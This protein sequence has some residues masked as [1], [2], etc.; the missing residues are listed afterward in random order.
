MGAGAEG[1]GQAGKGRPRE[2]GDCV[3]EARTDWPDWHMKGDEKL[4]H[5]TLHEI[6]DG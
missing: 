3:G 2:A 6:G 1:E 4:R 5:A